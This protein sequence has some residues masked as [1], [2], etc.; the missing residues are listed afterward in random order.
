MQCP[1][2][3]STKNETKDSRPYKEYVRRR[4][5]CRDCGNRFT[6]IE[7][8]MSD[9]KDV[10]IRYVMSGF[11]NESLGKTLKTMLLKTLKKE[12]TESDF[13]DGVA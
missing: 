3:F 5:L 2:C 6:T 9:I 10:G 11:D 12:L 4:K 1:S 7:M 8:S 13:K